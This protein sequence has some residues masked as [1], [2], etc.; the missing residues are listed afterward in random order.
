MKNW[1]SCPRVLWFGVCCGRDV[2]VS[3]NVH[4]SARVESLRFIRGSRGRLADA[5]L[6]WISRAGTPCPSV[7]CELWVASRSHRSTMR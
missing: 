3:V 4:R 1:T 6:N 7:L 2:S 5:T